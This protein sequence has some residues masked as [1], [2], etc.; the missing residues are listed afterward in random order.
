MDKW[1]LLFKKLFGKFLP[2][3]YDSEGNFIPGDIENRVQQTQRWIVLY[4]VEGKYNPT[5]LKKLMTKRSGW[6]SS[7]QSYLSS[8][9]FGF[10]LPSI[11]IMLII[12]AG[13]LVL[14]NGK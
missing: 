10:H 12:V 14:K 7:V 3:T 13:Y 9:S 1:E 11:T 6:Q 2:G 5:I 4:G 8:F